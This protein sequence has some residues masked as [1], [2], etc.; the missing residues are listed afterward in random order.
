MLTRKAD[1]AFSRYIRNRDSTTYLQNE[2]GLS[3]PAGRCIT[4]QKIIPTS[5]LGSGHAGHF[6][7]RG[8]KLLRYDPRNVHLQCVSCNKYN[9]GEQWKHGRAIERLYGEVV[10]RELEELDAK[11]K[12]EGHKFT[13]EELEEVIKKYGYDERNSV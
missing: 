11:Y 8:N 10:L 6:I 12:R 2:E 4:C 13:R 3:V 5:G 7:P 1:Q 9:Q